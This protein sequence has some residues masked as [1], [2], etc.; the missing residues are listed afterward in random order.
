MPLR[1]RKKEP[2]QN[3]TAHQKKKRTGLSKILPGD[4]NKE[5]AIN[6]ELRRGKNYPWLLE[7]IKR[8]FQHK[9]RTSMPRNLK[10]MLASISD[11]PFNDKDWQFEIKW[12]GY[13]SLAYVSNGKADLR[14]RNNLSF[15]LKYAALLDAFKQWPVQAI[16]DGEVVILAEDGKADFAALQAWDKEPAGQLL[17]FAFDLLWLE[18]IDLQKE[19]LSVRRELLKRI[20][21]ETGPIRFS[22]SIEECGVDFFKA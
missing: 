1:K 3:R 8:E 4:K 14:S 6:I 12:D 20:I 15:N 11:E 13:R 10:P 16:I 17:Y 9:R 18:G 2:I 22:E 7:Q 21:P 19:P 5:N